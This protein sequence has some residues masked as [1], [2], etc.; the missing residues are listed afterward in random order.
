[1]RPPIVNSSIVVCNPAVSGGYE[2]GGKVVPGHPLEAP[3]E[4]SGTQFGGKGAQGRLPLPRTPAERLAAKYSQAAPDSWQLL[5]DQYNREFG[6]QLR[7]RLLG[8]TAEMAGAQEEE[9]EPPPRKEKGSLQGE[10][11]GGIESPVVSNFWQPKPIA[12]PK[13]AVRQY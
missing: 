13:Q 3:A 12:K 4:Q 7:R 8:H 5:I 11:K 1:M 9:E 6:E 10:G 2:K